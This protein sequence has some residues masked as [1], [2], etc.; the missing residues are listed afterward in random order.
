VTIP[1]L[2]EDFTRVDSNQIPHH[3]AIIPDGN[4]RW[5]KKHLLETIR[6][7]NQGAE[8]LMDIVEA[9]KNFGVKV[10][11]FYLFSTENWS[12][13]KREVQALMHLLETYL[14]KQRETMVQNGIR[15]HTI[16]NL[17]PFPKSVL[18]E[19]Q[20]T[21]H[22]TKE[23]DEIDLIFALN[24]GARDEIKRGVEKIVDAILEN[25]LQRDEISEA[26]ISN[27]LDT[28][29]WPDPELLIRTSGELR[30]SNFLLWQ[31]SYGEIHTTDV[32]WPD[33]TPKDLALALLDF[34]KRKR[35]WGGD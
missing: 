9:A 16:G 35:R 4:R 31:I 29:F 34:Q 23:C 14:V 33:F 19:L 15:L 13:P 27:H 22:A 10:I 30:V 24:Y 2:K 11:T 18:Q 3:I 7:H 26:V 1:F 5:A 17:V 20:A 21:R 32:L 12:R 28:S 25:R 6:G 8:V